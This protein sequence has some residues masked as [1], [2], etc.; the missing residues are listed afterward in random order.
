MTT[1]KKKIN[2]TDL[3]HSHLAG[4]M[5]RAGETEDVGRFWGEGFNVICSMLPADDTALLIPTHN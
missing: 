1:D 4:M 2:Y 5:W 3:P